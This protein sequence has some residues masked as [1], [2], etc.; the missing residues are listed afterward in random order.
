MITS[1]IIV[2]LAGTFGA[3][4]LTSDKPDEDQVCRD[5]SSEKQNSSKGNRIVFQDRTN[6]CGVA[7][8]KM[9]LE[10]FGHASTLRN[11][12]R[13]LSLSTEGTDM[14]QLKEAAE[15]YGLHAYGYKLGKEDLARIR[16]P[17]IIFLKKNHFVVA[18]SFDASGFL[19]VR[20]PATGRVR[21]S[22]HAL[23]ETWGGEALVFASNQTVRIRTRNLMEKK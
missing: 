6:N 5:S 8:L 10:H 14:Q 7:A 23:A 20:D 9:I 18:D 1:I 12:E 21:I 11:L 2:L 22:Q 4:W 17:I 19:L 16:Y 13:K 15:A 3:A